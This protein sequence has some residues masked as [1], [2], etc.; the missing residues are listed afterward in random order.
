MKVVLSIAVLLVLCAVAAAKNPP[1]AV[2]AVEEP[3][4]CNCPGGVCPLRQPA[5][6]SHHIPRV[7]VNV[8]ESSD[9]PRVRTRTVTRTRVDRARRS[10]GSSGNYGSSGSSRRGRERHVER[11]VSYGSTGGVSVGVSYGSTGGR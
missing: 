2:I 10:A 8:Y 3:A 5:V 6:H 9:A 1:E 4:V 11:S 7:S